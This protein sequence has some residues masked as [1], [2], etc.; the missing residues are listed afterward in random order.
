[1]EQQAAKQAK[2]EAQSSQVNSEV[3]VLEVLEVYRPNSITAELFESTGRS[4]DGYYTS[5]EVKALLVDYI[6]DKQLADP[7]NQRIVKPDDV[8]REA[9]SKKG[10]QLE[11]V[12]RD[13]TSER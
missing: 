7:K 4:K 9:L 10:E 12:P 2:I 1:M 8:L 3:K 5:S 13:Q 6:K 11:R